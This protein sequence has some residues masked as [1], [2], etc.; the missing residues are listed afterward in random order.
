MDMGVEPF[1]ISSIMVAVVAQ[2][3]ART[4]CPACKGS[5]TADADTCH[6]LQVDPANPPFIIPRGSNL[7]IAGECYLRS[8]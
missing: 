4:L 6:F 3:L 7:G 5:Y 2:R 8:G 1:L